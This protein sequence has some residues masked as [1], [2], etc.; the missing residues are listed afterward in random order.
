MYQYGGI[1][2]SISQKQKLEGKGKWK[3]H[4]SEARTFSGVPSLGLNPSNI[5]KE[6]FQQ[7]LF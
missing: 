2:V 4:N 3:L 5:Y 1:D 6:A 7:S